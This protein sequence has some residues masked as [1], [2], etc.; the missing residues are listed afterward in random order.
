MAPFLF[1]TVFY[2]LGKIKTD[3]TMKTFNYIIF[4]SIFFLIYGLLNYYIYRKGY[5]VFGQTS[6]SRNVFRTLFFIISSSFIFGRTLE[7]FWL[8]W[9]SQSLIWIGSY[10]LAAM[11]YF[12]LGC[13]LIDLFRL[14]NKLFKFLPTKNNFSTLKTKQIIASVFIGVVIAILIGGHIN[15]GIPKIREVSVSIDK[16]F[17][18]SEPLNIVAVSDIHLGTIIGRNRFESIVD[19]INKLHPDIILLPGDIIDEDLEPVIRANLGESLQKLEARYGVYA[20]TGNHEY[21]GGVERAVK[22]LTD[23]GITVLRDTVVLID[24]YFYVAGRE[25]LTI[26]RFTNKT[27]KSL[28]DLV[29][30]INKKYAVI[31]LDHQPRNLN[32]AVKN[33]IDLQISGHTHHG[34]IWPLNYFAEI[35]YEVSWGYKQKGNT[36]IYVSS[37]VGTWGPPVRLGNRPEIVNIKMSFKNQ[38]EKKLN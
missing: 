14:G 35:I 12:F 31:L 8:S 33:E 5:K 29:Q 36:H 24:N 25:D 1:Y 2:K 22:Y 18:R 15:A 28:R 34:Q 13:V 38:V 16:N 20:S 30:N 37:G 32:D 7:N 6:T 21:I 23:N 26:S 10:W 4:F 27:R 11:L 3:G 9:F 17:E 19:Q